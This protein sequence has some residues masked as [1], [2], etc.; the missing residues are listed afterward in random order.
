ML[1]SLLSAAHTAFQAITAPIR[2]RPDPRIVAL[3]TY[4]SLKDEYRRAKVAGDLRK[5]GELAPRVKEA[6]TARLR[7]ELGAGR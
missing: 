3:N 5:Q 2:H 7:A 1:G 4:S 6:M